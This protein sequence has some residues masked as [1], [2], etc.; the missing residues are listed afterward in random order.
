MKISMQNY[1]QIY[2][3]KTKENNM[4]CTNNL[5]MVDKKKLATCGQT[6]ITGMVARPRGGGVSELLLVGG[7]TPRGHQG[8]VQLI[9]A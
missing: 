6:C 5:Q 7:A 4:L 9:V 1:K 3:Q 8:R 2:E